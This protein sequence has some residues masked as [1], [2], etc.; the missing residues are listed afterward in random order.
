VTL[1]FFNP[2]IEPFGEFVK[3]K[4]QMQVL[5]SKMPLAE[6]ISLLDCDYDGAT[7]CEAIEDLRGL[8][9]GG[10]RCEICFRLRLEQTARYAKAHFFDV[11]GTT[12]TVSPHKNAQLINRIGDETSKSIGTAY[13]SSDF[14]KKGGYQRSVELSKLHGLYRQNYCGCESNL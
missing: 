4:E 6:R 5:L 2:N 7:F 3:R 11:F 10:A 14:K 12:L 8:P 9:E 13:L 1:F